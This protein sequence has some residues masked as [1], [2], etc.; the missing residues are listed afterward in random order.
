MVA[1]SYFFPALVGKL[2]LLATV[3]VNCLRPLRRRFDNTARPPRVFIR[4]RKPWVRSRLILLGWYVRLVIPSPQKV[5]DHYHL[6]MEP[7]TP[8]PLDGTGMG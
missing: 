4:A 5:N 2:I 1:I 6:D 7:A 3:T 8:L